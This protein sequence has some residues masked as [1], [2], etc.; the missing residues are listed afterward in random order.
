MKWCI[1]KGFTAAEPTKSSNICSDQRDL[2]L[3]YLWMN[4]HAT[5]LYFKYSSSVVTTV[6]NSITGEQH[7]LSLGKARKEANDVNL[8]HCLKKWPFKARPECF[9]LYFLCFCCSK[10]TNGAIKLDCGRN[11]QWRKWV[12][13][14][15]YGLLSKYLLDFY[16]HKSIPAFQIYT[17]W[18]PA[19]FMVVRRL[20]ICTGK[21]ITSSVTGSNCLDMGL[22]LP[23]GNDKWQ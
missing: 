23:V 13:M 2:D 3:R 17:T 12:W 5:V 16:L 7:S 18:K 8:A 4:S 21:G 14:T 22:A 19:T 11:T 20:W 6:S 1:S 9:V 10:F 15:W